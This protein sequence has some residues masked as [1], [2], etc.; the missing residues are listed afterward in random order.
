[1]AKHLVTGS[2]GFVGSEI[3]KK[4]VKLNHDVV[5]IDIIEDNVISNI[6]DFY[7]IDISEDLTK[8]NA[9]FSNVSSVH[10][11]A[12]LVPLTKAG[13]NFFKSNVIGT[14]NILKTSIFN[15]VKHFSHMSSSAIF[16]A[17]YKNNNVDTNVLLP[18]ENYG[19]S[20]LLAEKE[21]L[22]VFVICFSDNLNIS[23]P[24]SSSKSFILTFS[25]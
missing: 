4:L 10:H 12:A 14:K 18:K 23:F 22:K 2:S 15:N 20:K 1:M 19:Y 16:G 9:I 3:V 8:Y 13:K 21:V 25:R 6:S 24:V 17:P 5:S 7:K 11:N